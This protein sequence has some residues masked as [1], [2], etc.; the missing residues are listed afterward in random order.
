MR[1]LCDAMGIASGTRLITSLKMLTEG[2][3]S[4]ERQTEASTKT[5]R[6]SRRIAR[7]AAAEASTR[8]YAAGE[9]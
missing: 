6:H 4:T 5:A 7:A 3:C 8:D 1:R 9:F 2:G